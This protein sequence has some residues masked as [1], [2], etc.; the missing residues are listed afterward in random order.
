MLHTKNYFNYQKKYLGFEVT[1]FGLLSEML[2]EDMSFNNHD[3][4]E[5][6]FNELLKK[7]RKYV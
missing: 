1:F 2:Y 7:T 5:K 3:D 6:E 4:V